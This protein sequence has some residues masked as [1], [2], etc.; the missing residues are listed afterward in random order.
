MLC[1]WVGLSVI[2]A[3]VDQEHFCHAASA[4]LTLSTTDATVAF[5]STV[6]SVG[7]ALFLS[8]KV[9]EPFVTEAGCE[10]LTL[11]HYL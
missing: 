1:V 6:F 5:L 7:F 9:P 8:K 3:A 2:V 11:P 4:G 10:P